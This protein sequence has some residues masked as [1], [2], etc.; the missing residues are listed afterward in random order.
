M[1]EALVN[2]ADC[3]KTDMLGKRYEYYRTMN[4]NM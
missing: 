4:R 1:K 2:E 3:D